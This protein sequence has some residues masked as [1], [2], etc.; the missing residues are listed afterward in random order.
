MRTAQQVI[1]IG[2]GGIGHTV[3]LA[4]GEMVAALF[5][6]VGHVVANI[7]QIGLIVQ[8]SCKA[9]I[10]AVG[11]TGVQVWVGRRIA[12][13]VASGEAIAAVHQFIRGAAIGFAVSVV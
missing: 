4:N 12:Y 13:V 1:P 10:N 9:I 5:L 2:D 3:H 8:V 6:S 11:S 7:R